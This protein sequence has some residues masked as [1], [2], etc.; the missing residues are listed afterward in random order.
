MTE[1][2]LRSVNDPETGT[3][4]TSESNKLSGTIKERMSVTVPV[5]QALLCLLIKRYC[6]C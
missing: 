2:S 4:E 3:W 1:Q 6:A 5:N